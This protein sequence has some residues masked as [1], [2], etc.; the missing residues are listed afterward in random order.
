MISTHCNLRLPSLCDPPASAS[1]VGGITGACHH[2]RLM[3]VFLVEMG[4]HHV[5]QAGLKLLVS[6]DPPASASQSPGITVHLGFFWCVCD[7]VLLLLPRLECNGG[8]ISAHHKLCLWRQGF[9]TLVRLVSKS[10][11]QVIHL[12]RPPKVLGLQALLLVHSQTGG[13]HTPVT[14]GLGRGNDC[15]ARSHCVT[16]VGVLWHERGS[17]DPL[18]SASQVAGI[19]GICHNLQCLTLSPR[20]ECSE[21][22]SVAQARVQYSGVISAHCNLHLLGSS[23]SCASAS[24]VAGSSW[25]Y[26]DRVLPCCCTEL[27][28]ES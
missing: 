17:S 6:R 5:S 2:T 23:D 11:P 21:S 14:T 27:S 15:Q 28:I 20:L 7:G 9:S 8:I 18:T 24:R 4:F 12:P 19:M 25:D 10:R 1:R 13:P 22:H 3:F 16:Q 26:R